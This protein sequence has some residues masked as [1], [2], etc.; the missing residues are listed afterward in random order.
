MPSGCSRQS[1]KNPAG[2][3]PPVPLSRA[4]ERQPSAEVRRGVRTHRAK[5]P[6]WSRRHRGPARRRQCAPGHT[7]DAAKT[8]KKTGRTARIRITAA[9]PEQ[10]PRPAPHLSRRNEWYYAQARQQALGRKASR[11]LGRS[12]EGSEARRAFAARPC[13]P[14][15]HSRA[16]RLSRSQDEVVG[17]G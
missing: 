14:A 11:D 4:A 5:P 12:E 2:L 3:P 7:R 9:P 1:S 16:P 10:A 15:L 17:L 8:S 13:A 6:R